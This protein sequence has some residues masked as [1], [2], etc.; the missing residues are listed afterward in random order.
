MMQERETTHKL[1]IKQDCFLLARHL[2]QSENVQD[3]SVL[4]KAVCYA[5][6]AVI[7]LSIMSSNNH[8]VSIIMHEHES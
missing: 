1:C 7:I 8:H 5:S 3:G 6:F 2:K 4:S